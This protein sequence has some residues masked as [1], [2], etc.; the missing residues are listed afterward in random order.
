MKG[1]VWNFG[2]YK[3]CVLELDGVQNSPARIPEGKPAVGC[4]DLLTMPSLRGLVLFLDFVQTTPRK[5]KNKEE[6]FVS[7]IKFLRVS[8]YLFNN[9]R[10]LT[11]K[12]S[13]EN[14]S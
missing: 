3:P 7:G 13:E 10:W 11:E 5:L 12:D 8:N 2:P 4:V 6:C 9:A 14:N 1:I